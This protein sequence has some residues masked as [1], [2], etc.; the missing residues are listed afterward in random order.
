MLSAL[1]S[2][3]AR[4]GLAGLETLVGTP[5][6]VGGALKHG[7]NRAVEMS[8]YLQLVEVVDGSGRLQLRERDDL[9]LSADS[10]DIDDLLLVAAD[11]ELE[12][13]DK[14]A[15]VK[16]MRKAWIHRKGR[17]PFSFQSAGRLFQD[18]RGGSVRLLIEQAGLTGTKVGGVELS[19]RDAN[20]M[21]T[22]AGATARDAL[23]LI[24]L[25]RSRVREQR[26]VELELA[27]SIW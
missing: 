4:H 23:R 18:P 7:A 12:A 10:G 22:S 15:I 6:T 14:D 8:Q 17:Q 16:R 3:S 21:I 26:H 13:D 27:L 11:F 1:I 5:G 20:Y 19:E 2:Q 9:G 24:D 25:V